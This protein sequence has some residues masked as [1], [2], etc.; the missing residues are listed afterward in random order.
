M[1]C[2]LPIITT[3]AGG[4]VDIIHQGDNGFII[5]ENVSA[6][7]N[8]IYKLATDKELRKKMGKSSRKIAEGLDINRCVRSYEQLY[9]YYLQNVKNV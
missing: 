3:P 2:G 8:A 7:S 1:A 9:L 4:V 5:D 6:Y